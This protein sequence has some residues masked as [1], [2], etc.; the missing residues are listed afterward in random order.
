YSSATIT[1]HYKVFDDALAGA[2]HQI[3]YSVKANSNIAI[4]RLLADLGA[5][6][7]VV[8]AGEIYRLE[9]AGAPLD[10]VVFSGVGKTAAEMRYALQRGIHAFNVESEAELELLSSVASA[11]GLEA[12]V[13]LRVNPDVDPQTHPYIATGLRESKFGI[14]W[15]RAEASYARAAALP[16]IRV[17]GVDCHIG[18][19]LTSLAPFLDAVDRMLE[20]ATRLRAAGLP[21]EDLD[22]GGGLG[23]TYRDEAP[24]HPDD[25]ARAIIERTRGCGMKLLFEPGRVIVG[26]AGVLLMSVLYQKTSEARRFVIVDAAMN[27][28]IRPALYGAYHAIRPVRE[29]DAAEDT[30]DVVGPV[31]E[32]GDFFAKQ[33]GLTPVAPGDLLA[34]MSAGAYGFSMSSNYNARPRAAEVLVRGGRYDVVR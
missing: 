27:D 12:P 9:I 8:S 29:S 23:I 10:R 3:H 13:S 15:Q 26:N 14:P 17:V 32:S 22:L 34:L 7:D 31:C 1:R 2:P 11:M 6:F 24:P 28:A 16:G 19:Q 33:R 25:L 4:L 20:L 5:G 21:I 30:V 18:S